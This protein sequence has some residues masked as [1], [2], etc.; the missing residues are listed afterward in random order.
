MP[1]IGEDS[2]LEVTRDVA[3]DALRGSVTSLGAPF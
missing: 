3:R 1:G 2:F